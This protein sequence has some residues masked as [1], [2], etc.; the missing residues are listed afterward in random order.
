MLSRAKYGLLLVVVLLIVTTVDASAQEPPNLWV[1]GAGVVSI[2]DPGASDSYLYPALGGAAP[3]M[4]VG[5][6]KSI[7]PRL[8]VGFEIGYDGLIEGMQSGRI[9]SRPF[10]TTHRDTTFTELLAWSER[11]EASVTPTFV[12][13]FTVAWR[14]TVRHYTTS[15]NEVNDLKVGVAGGVDVTIRVSPRVFVAPTFRLHW[16]S[17]G[18][19]PQSIPRRGVGPFVTRLGVSLGVGL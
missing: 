4:V 7:R 8:R 2:H 18:D 12:G 1:T 16:I 9:A 10:R 5:I 3:G 17:G 11:E 14:Q 6:Q 15:D 19:R 13:G